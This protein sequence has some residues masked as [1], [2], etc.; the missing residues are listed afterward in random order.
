MNGPLDVQALEQSLKEIVRRHESLRT[1]FD[2]IDGDPVQVIHPAEDLAI[3]IQ[4]ISLEAKDAK[5]EKACQLAK[6]EARSLFNRRIQL[7][8]VTREWKNKW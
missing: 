5:K 4:D 8:S 1:T 7:P 3:S 2:V 6:E